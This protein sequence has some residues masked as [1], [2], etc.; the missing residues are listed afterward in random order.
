VSRQVWVFDLEGTLSS[1]ETWKGVGRWLQSHGRAARYR[2]FFRGHLPGALLAKA[3]LINKRRYQN[4]WMSDLAA[5]FAGMTAAQVADVADWVVEN[6]LWPRLRR[7]V[8]QELQDGLAAGVRIV[9][10]SGTFEPVLAAFAGR[11]DPLVEVLGTPLSCP[12]DV[13]DGRLAGPVNV[14][15]EK[16]RRVRRYLGRPQRAYGDTI[17]DGDLLQ[18]AQQAVAVCPD[19]ELALQAARRDWRVISCDG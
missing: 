8:M 4:K 2:A 19:K 18:L 12:Q 15:Q 6:E 14:A 10:A 9:L 3:G 16:A 1:G 13:C 11:I 7:P 17:S 5:F